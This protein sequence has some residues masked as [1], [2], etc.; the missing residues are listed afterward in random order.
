MHGFFLAIY[1]DRGLLKCCYSEILYMT[2]NHLWKYATIEF[3]AD[4]TFA[5]LKGQNMATIFTTITV[6]KCAWLPISSWLYLSFNFNHIV[7]VFFMQGNYHAWLLISASTLSLEEYIIP[8]HKTIWRLY[9]RSRYH[10]S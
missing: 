3:W 4:H 6:V 8:Q 5:K 10:Y 9:A 1:L 2:Q 7:I